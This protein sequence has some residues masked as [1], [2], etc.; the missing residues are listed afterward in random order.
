M[1]LLGKGSISSWLA[2]LLNVAQYAIVLGIVIASALTAVSFFV[3]LKG[4]EIDLPV[5]FQVDGRALPV[6]APS[7]GIEA[8]YIEDARGSLTFRPPSG[9]YVVP[10]TLLGV[11]AILAVILW[12]LSQLQAVFR[13]LRDG[14][15]FVADN[16]PRIRSIAFIVIFGELIR[17]GLVFAANYYAMTHFSAGGV[18]FDA[19]V[20]VNIFAIIHGLIILV[21]AEIFRVGTQLDEDQSLTI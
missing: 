1:R 8:T 11:I 16:A 2:V 3:D 5:S 10:A 21:I 14:Q 12:G 19:E 20:D 9:L 7:L 18:R 4:A 6:S 15:P 13:T 17:A